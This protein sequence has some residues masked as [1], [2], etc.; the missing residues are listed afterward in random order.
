MTKEQ[1]AKLQELKKAIVAG[2]ELAKELQK[3][4]PEP[5]H[6]APLRGR[7]RATLESVQALE[8]EPVEEP[9]K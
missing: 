7:V 3:L 2:E 6:A 1:H 9:K 8:K 5:I 4:N